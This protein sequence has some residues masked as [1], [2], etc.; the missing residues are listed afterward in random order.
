MT[1]RV[2]SSSCKSAPRVPFCQVWLLSFQAGSVYL[3]HQQDIYPLCQWKASRPPGTQLGHEGVIVFYHDF[4]SN[5]LYILQAQFPHCQLSQTAW[6]QYCVCLRDSPRALWVFS[7]ETGSFHSPPPAHTHTPTDVI[8]YSVWLTLLRLL[9]EVS[10]LPP[11]IYV[12]PPNSSPCSPT[13]ISM[14]RD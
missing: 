4:D 8:K 11:I 3:E 5:V 2:S 7:D 10:L 6:K 13:I 9:P 14:I 1:I 12:Q